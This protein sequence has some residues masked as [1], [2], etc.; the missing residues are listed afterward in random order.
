MDMTS[1][2]TRFLS[3]VEILRE[4]GED[5]EDFFVEYHRLTDEV[6]D[7]MDEGRH[8]SI[9]DVLNFCAENEIEL[10]P[11]EIRSVYADSFYRYERGAAEMMLMGQMTLVEGMKERNILL[12]QR[13]LDFIKSTVPEISRILFVGGGPLPM[14]PLTYIVNDRNI[15][16]DILD[17]SSEAVELSKGLI[18]KVGAAPRVHVLPA[19]PI[20]DFVPESYDVIVL[21]SMVGLTIDEK[22]SIYQQLAS[23][24]IRGQTIITRDIDPQSFASLCYC[25]FPIDQLSEFYVNVQSQKSDP[26]VIVSEVMLKRR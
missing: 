15:Q 14:T 18:K 16:V 2:L 8:I 23:H 19:S 13:E 9:R 5:D 24:V 21:A 25:P 4:L 1:L 20:E 12:S 6:D 17:K 10:N 22:T 3:S 11:D 7:C 26:P